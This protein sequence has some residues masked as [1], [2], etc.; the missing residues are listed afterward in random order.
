MLSP[1]K[2]LSIYVI[3]HKTE[4]VIWFQNAPECKDFRSKFVLFM[5]GIYFEYVKFA[6][7]D[8]YLIIML[9]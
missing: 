2:K 8:K 3:L 7:G 6:S 1:Y 5:C 4:V 9:F